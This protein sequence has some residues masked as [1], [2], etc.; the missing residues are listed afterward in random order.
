MSEMQGAEIEDE[1]SVLMYMTKS[2]IEEQR[3]SLLIMTQRHN[4]GND[5]GV[6]CVT[7]GCPRKLVC[8]IWSH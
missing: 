8:F 5:I 1:G 3:S 2:E 6:T 7:F 4:F